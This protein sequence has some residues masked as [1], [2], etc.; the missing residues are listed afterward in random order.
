MNT[1]GGDWTKTKIEILVEY[2]QA[3]LTIMSKHAIQS[4]TGLNFVTP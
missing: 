4:H 1:F 3:Y 2:A